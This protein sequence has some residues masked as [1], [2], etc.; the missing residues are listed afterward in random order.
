MFER[1][2]DRRRRLFELIQCNEKQK[3]TNKIFFCVIPFFLFFFYYF[4]LFF[5]FLSFTL[6]DI[7]QTKQNRMLNNKTK[8]KKNEIKFN[9]QKQMYLY[10]YLYIR[11]VLYLYLC[12]CPVSMPASPLSHQ[13]QTQTN[14]IRTHQTAPRIDCLANKLLYNGRCW[15]S[16]CCSRCVCALAKQW[17]KQCMRGSIWCCFEAC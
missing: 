12:L 1:L 10:L 4:S 14:P 11:L 5:F 15:A 17:G 13:S 9:K 2:F 3:S 8:Q 7:C 16:C 6:C